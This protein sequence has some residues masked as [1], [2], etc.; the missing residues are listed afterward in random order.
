[1]EFGLSEDETELLKQI[2]LHRIKA[3]LQGEKSPP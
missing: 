3:I 1:M 2:I